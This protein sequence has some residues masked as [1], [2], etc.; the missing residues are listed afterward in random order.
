VGLTA[1]LDFFGVGKK[2]VAFAGILVRNGEKLSF[3]YLNVVFQRSIQRLEEDHDDLK[4]RYPF[5][6]RERTS[7]SEDK[8]RASLIYQF[9]RK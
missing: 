3:V 7:F 1:S 4:S 9:I 6:Q 2:F 5:R 8:L